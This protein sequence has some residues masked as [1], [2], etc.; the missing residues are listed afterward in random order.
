VL[1]HPARSPLSSIRAS[2]TAKDSERGCG[3]GWRRRARVAKD[4]IIRKK[5]WALTYDHV[6]AD[7]NVTAVSFDLTIMARSSPPSVRS[8]GTS[9]TLSFTSQQQETRARSQ[10]RSC[11]GAVPRRLDSIFCNSIIYDSRYS[12]PR[13]QR[14]RFDGFRRNENRRRLTRSVEGA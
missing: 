12:L 4:G 10:T 6:R 1:L 9:M 8:K 5:L 7:S 11:E 13:S 14:Y 2:P 3:K